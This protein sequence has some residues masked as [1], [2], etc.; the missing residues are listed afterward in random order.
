MGESWIPAFA[1][2]IEDLDEDPCVV[3][4]KIRLLADEKGE[5]DEKGGVKGSLI[6]AVREPIVAGETSKIP[7]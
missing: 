4:L 6:K 7:L 3:A 1:S 5:K 2:K